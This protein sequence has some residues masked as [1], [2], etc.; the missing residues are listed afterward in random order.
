MGTVVTQ[1]YP[2]WILRKED[3]NNIGVVQIMPF[4]FAACNAHGSINF[5]R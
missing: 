4:Y 2:Q 3:Q 5:T 1:S